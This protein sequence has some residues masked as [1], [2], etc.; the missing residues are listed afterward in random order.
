MGTV[1]KKSP[2]HNCVRLLFS[3]FC[4]ASRRTTSSRRPSYR[5]ICPK[6]LS[7]TCSLPPMMVGSTSRFRTAWNRTDTNPKVYSMSSRSLRCSFYK[8]EYDAVLKHYSE[9]KG[10]NRFIA[11][12]AYKKERKE[13]VRQSFE[14]SDRASG[15]HYEIANL[16]QSLAVTLTL[17]VKSIRRSAAPRES[18]FRNIERKING[19][20]NA[21]KSD[22][23]LISHR[24][25]L[26]QCPYQACRSRLLRC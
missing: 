19:I 22:F 15:S 7:W 16:P 13:F 24:S 23:C 21:R 26:C 20:G 9:L 2:L 5:V 6:N 12:S 17:G 4:S 10:S 3:P 18:E 25:P 14:V 11:L 1:G 8:P